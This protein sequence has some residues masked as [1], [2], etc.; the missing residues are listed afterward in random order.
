MTQQGPANQPQ[1]QIRMQRVS[2]WYFGTI[3]KK[4]SVRG[5]SL[6]SRRVLSWR[7]WPITSVSYTLI[8]LVSM[9]CMLLTVLTGE[10]RVRQEG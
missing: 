6:T 9:H 8:Y 3:R 4:L 1:G 10:S 5:L 7:S 2:G